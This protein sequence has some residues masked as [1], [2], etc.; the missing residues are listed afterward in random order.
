MG[1]H[2]HLAHPYSLAI[3]EH[4]KQLEEK[5][6]QPKALFFVLG[7][8]SLVG[9]VT[10]LGGMKLIVDLLGFLYPAYM[11]FKS[12]DGAAPDS[13]TQWLT[14]WV[15]FSFLSIFEHVFAFVVDI[16]PFYT[17]IKIA[18]VVWMWYPSTNGAQVVYD[19]VLRPFLLPY[20][21]GKPNKKAE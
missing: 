1:T 12:M 14:Y 21:E 2:R 16:I 8:L 17:L 19:S 13:R 4:L 6:G 20:L 7:C 5:T 15:V 10:L 18:V 11:S 3:T 9:L